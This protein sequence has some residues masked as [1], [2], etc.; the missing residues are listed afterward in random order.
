M[1]YRADSNV[2]TKSGVIQLGPI[3]FTM[4]QVKTKLLLF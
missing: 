2:A 1:F 4:T 3:K